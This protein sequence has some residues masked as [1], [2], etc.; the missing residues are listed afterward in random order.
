M[1]GVMTVKRTIRRTPGVT[2]PSSALHTCPMF[3]SRTTHCFARTS[4]RTMRSAA[5]GCAFGCAAVPASPT[6]AAQ[7]T[8]CTTN[9]AR[10]PAIRNLDI[11][12]P[13]VSGYRTERGLYTR[14]RAERQSECAHG[15]DWH[16]YARMR[17]AYERCADS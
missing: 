13:L 5:A 16:I 15:F 6:R 14:Q 7:A 1:L 2:F 9:T 17:H 3:S 11:L 10:V 12:P 4:P 8:A